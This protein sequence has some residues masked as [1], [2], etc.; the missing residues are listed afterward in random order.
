MILV[1]VDDQGANNEM[2]L[3]VRGQHKG[4]VDIPHTNK[5]EINANII[6]S[7]PVLKVG[8]T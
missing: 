2:M 7:P 1:F 4:Q 8:T 6:T 5:P 3:D